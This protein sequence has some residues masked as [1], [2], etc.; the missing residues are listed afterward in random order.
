VHAHREGHLIFHIGGTPGSIEVLEQPN[1]L[2]EDTVVAVNPWE[3]HNFSAERFWLTGRFFLRAVRQQPNGSQAFRGLRFGCT[4]FRRTGKT[5]EPKI[6]GRRLPWFAARPSLNGLDGEL[7]SPDRRLPR[8]ELGRQEY[9]SPESYTG[10]RSHRLSAC[11]SRSNCW[12]EG[13]GGRD[14]TRCDPRAEAGLF[15]PA[16][17]YKLFPYPDRRQRL[18]LYV[19][20]AC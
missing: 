13:I 2:C 20:T 8:G 1:L 19:N 12:R 10:A 6:S 18:N 14:R 11:A 5:L 15:A 9:A 4:K 7:R 3:P 17:F 16:I